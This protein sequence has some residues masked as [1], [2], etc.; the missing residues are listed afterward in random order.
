MFEECKGVHNWFNCLNCGFL[1]T[2]LCPLE[3]DDALD[4]IANRIRMMED[5]SF[6][7]FKKELSNHK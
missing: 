3:G 5:P 6:E 1:S 4:K 2:Q 7:G